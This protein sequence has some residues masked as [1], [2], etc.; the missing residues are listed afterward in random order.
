MALLHSAFT[1][2]S[3][4]VCPSQNESTSAPRT[5]V[6]RCQLA[7]GVAVLFGVVRP[8]PNLRDARDS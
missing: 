8:T 3:L 6:G 7:G 2:S 5:N 1:F 4:R